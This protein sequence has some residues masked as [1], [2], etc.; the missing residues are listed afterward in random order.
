MSRV[1][2][3]AVGGFVLGALAIVVV[4]ILVFGG[5]EVFTHKTKA[6]VYFNGS[7]GGLVA[8]APVTFRGVRVGTVSHVSLVLDTSAMRARIPVYLT[9]E[10]ER[11]R[12]TGRSESEPV[13]SKVIQA[14]L[15]AKLEFESLVTGQMRV[16][17]DFVSNTHRDP[18]PLADP[19]EIPSVSSDLQGF[20]EQLT[21]TPISETVNQVQRTMAAIERVADQLSSKIDPLSDRAREALESTTRTMDTATTAIAGMEGHAAAVLEDLQGLTDDG[22]RQLATRGQ[23]LSQTLVTADKALQTSRDLVT[24]ANGLLARGSRPREDLESTLRDLAAS[25]NALRELTAAVGRD[26][27]MVVR[28]RGAR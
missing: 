23:E 6:V 8:C 13:L 17:L 12:F 3:A 27:A 4:G 14:G 22:R 24:A 2:P 9:L 26:P 16:D 28:G 18:V 10:P 5:G 20:R 7:V 15:T 25:A 21:R 11:V 1:S 19:P